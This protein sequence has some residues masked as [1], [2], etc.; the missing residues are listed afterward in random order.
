MTQSNAFEI[1]A[2]VRVIRTIGAV[3]NEDCI[4]RIGLLINVSTILPD[5]WS[6]LINGKIIQFYT[7]ELE[8]VE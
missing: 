1:G 3:F 6:V 2:L 8:K 7:S 4:G 5:G